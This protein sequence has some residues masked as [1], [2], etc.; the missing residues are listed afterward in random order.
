MFNI[1]EEMQNFEP[2]DLP[3]LS[4]KIGQIPEDTKNAIELYN[5]AL[6]DIKG[7]NEDMAI[8][9]LK[10]AI[11][12]YPAF[13][14]AMNMMG[15]CYDS[16]GDEESARAM[17]EKVIEMENNSL[18]AA[19][20]LDRMN[21]N[22]DGRTRLARVPGKKEGARV[23]SW[24]G[25]GLAPEKS[26]PYFLKYIL[27][28]IIGVIAMGAL[29]F[30][31]PTGKP[32]FT[33][34][35]VID[36]SQELARLQADNTKLNQDLENALADLRTASQKET[37]L[38]GEIEKYKHWNQEY[39]RIQTLAAEGKYRDVVTE[40]AKFKG[41]E[42]I[43]EDI[44]ADI[45]ALDESCKPKAVGQIYESAKKIYD[46]NSKNKSKDEYIKAASEFALAIEIMEQLETKPQNAQQIY[47]FGGKAKALSESPSKEEAIAEAIVY[48]NAAVDIDPNSDYGRYS[49]A[50]INELNSG[51]GIKH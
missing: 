32:L 50:R 20:F 41:L 15:L 49:K 1:N 11:A 26:T 17:F 40:I 18:R 3:T 38:L 51:K 37:Q 29:W 24:I 9:A 8:I 46:G 43:P 48:F 36:N 13:Y 23:F 45:A 42:G 6:D 22:E 5:K 34:E 27:G 7:H 12:I 31:L 39:R 19:D 25:S 44:N 16:L 47:Y 10:K 35:R 33:I 30:A 2:I 21:G 4:Q 28:I 14:E